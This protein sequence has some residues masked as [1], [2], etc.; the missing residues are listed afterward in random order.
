LPD[1]AELILLTDP[2]HALP[3]RVVRTGLRTIAYGT[4]DVAT[5]RLPHIPFSADIRAGDE[6][7]TSGL[8][9]NFPAGL[10]VG[11]VRQVTPDDSATFVLALA[12]PSAGLSRSGEVLVLHDVREP[13]SDSAG[14]AFE[15]TGPPEALP[16]TA[17]PVAPMPSSGTPPVPA[18]A[19]VSGGG[20]P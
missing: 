13:L 10:P 20:R 2:S 15:F 19:P 3:V 9:G 4:G 8:G 11:V 7:V 16:V 14:K 6:L 5:L 12:T 17:P 18:A 1:R